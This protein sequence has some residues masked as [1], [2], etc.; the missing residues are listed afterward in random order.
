MEENSD[1]SESDA[2]IESAPL[3]SLPRLDIVPV[4]TAALARPEATTSDPGPSPL[5]PVLPS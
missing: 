1:A 5:W 4:R 3:S 2:A